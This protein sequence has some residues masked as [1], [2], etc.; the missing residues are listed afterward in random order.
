MAGHSKWSNI[1]HRKG[2]ADEKRAKIFSKIGREIQVAVRS[3]GPDPET[4]N[5]LRDVIAK[6]RSYNMPNDNIQRSISRA[7]G[8][9]SSD[10]D[11]G[12]PIRRVRSRRCGCHGACADGQPQQ[13][14]R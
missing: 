14:S 4:N 6:A 1:K 12:N 3:G 7:A 9:N 5:V 2:A 8:D 13:D 11:G 10:V